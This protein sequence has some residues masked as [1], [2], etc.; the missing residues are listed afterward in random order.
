VIK[1]SSI[2]REEERREGEA[3]EHQEAQAQP[4]AA[5]AVCAYETR[6]AYLSFAHK[7]PDVNPGFSIL[8]LFNLQLQMVASSVGPLVLALMLQAIVAAPIISQTPGLETK[9]LG[10]EEQST[11]K[12]HL[13]ANTDVNVQVSSKGLMYA[14]D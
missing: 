7:S 5:L 12:F 4:H 10:Q 8:S 1:V 3:P 6:F 2:S 11:A 13:A 14:T 9:D